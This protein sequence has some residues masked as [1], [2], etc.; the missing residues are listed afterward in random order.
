MLGLPKT[1]PIPM[2]EFEA[3]CAGKGPQFAVHSVP[4]GN[5]RAPLERLRKDLPF[6]VARFQAH[7]S[8][9]R[10]QT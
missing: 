9:R 4:A 8:V 1:K 3:L 2:K 7:R 5:T 10:D 6:L